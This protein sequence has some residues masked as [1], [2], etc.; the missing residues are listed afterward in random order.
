[1]LNEVGVRLNLT[2]REGDTA[3]RLGV[4]E[5]VVVLRVQPSE[6]P[7][8]VAQGVAER[9]RAALQTGIAT[10][11][12]LQHL[13]VSIGIHLPEK[14]SR[15]ADVLR[16]ADRAMYAAKTAGKDRHSTFDR[17]DS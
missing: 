4:D 9:I 12:G 8:R 7:T 10:E 1:M 6:D 13:T 16:N 11:R 17:P 2:I 15:A 14:D 3:G 5:F